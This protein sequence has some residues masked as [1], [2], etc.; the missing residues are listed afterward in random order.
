MR[1]VVRPMLGFAQ[2]LGSE[3]NGRLARC[4]LHPERKL[5]STFLAEK[6]QLAVC[7]LPSFASE[8]PVRSMFPLFSEAETDPREAS[9]LRESRRLP[10]RKLPSRLTL[11][12]DMGH[13]E[14][15]HARLL[16]FDSGF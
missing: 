3:L 11:Y 9:L 2:P 10:G 7:R 1:P 15:S 14:I 13:K 4:A 16:R 6:H 5:L 8:V 12:P